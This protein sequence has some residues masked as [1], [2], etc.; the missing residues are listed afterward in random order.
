MK[1]KRCEKNSKLNL[2][3]GEVVEVKTVD[4]I[5]S[6]LD[7]KGTLEGLPFMPEMYKYCGKRF[8]VFKRV[9]K[10]IIEGLGTLRKIENVVI[11]E[12]AIC[13]GEYHGGCKRSCMLLW[14][15]AWL[16]RANP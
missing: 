5:M 3:P 10:L 6:T 9:N 4:E 7:E 12:K 16:K 8:K 11:L 15:E 14:K 13:S 2:V 1:A